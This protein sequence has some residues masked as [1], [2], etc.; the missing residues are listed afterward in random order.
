MCV[1]IHRLRCRLQNHQD[2]LRDALSRIYFQNTV[3]EWLKLRLDPLYSLLEKS[4][5]NSRSRDGDGDGDGA[6]NH[7]DEDQEKMMIDSEEASLA[8]A[9]IAVLAV[10][11]STV[12]AAAS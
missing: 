10:V 6:G 12:P 2:K 4:L 7:G 1:C 5:K 3:E 11:A 8:S 9:N